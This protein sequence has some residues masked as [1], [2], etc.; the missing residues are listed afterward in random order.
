MWV[1]ITARLATEANNGSNEDLWEMYRR[2]GVGGSA[3]VANDLFESQIKYSI[4]QIEHIKLLLPS[5][6]LTS[7]QHSHHRLHLTIDTLFDH[8]SSYRRHHC[9]AGFFGRS[10]SYTYSRLSG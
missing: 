9:P 1:F 10:S 7:S 4:L 8:A 5:K 3:A 6:I 2:Y